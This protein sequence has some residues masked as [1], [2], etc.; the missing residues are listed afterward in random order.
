MYVMKINPDG[1]LDV[2]LSKTS[3]DENIGHDICSFRDAM[4]FL[5]YANFVKGMKKP[6]ASSSCGSYVNQNLPRNNEDVDVVV[7]HV[8]SPSEFYVQKV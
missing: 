2:D 3:A 8:V 5:E 1:C 6:S 4:V 7:S